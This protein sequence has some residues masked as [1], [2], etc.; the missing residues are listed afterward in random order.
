[1]AVQ[2]QQ[3]QPSLFEE[4]ARKAMPD[5]LRYILHFITPDEETALLNTIDQQPWLTDL[6]R[7]VQHYGWKYDY[8]ARRVDESMRLGALPD[9]L[10]DYCQRLYDEGHFPK[11]PNQVIINEYQPGQG[12]APHID[13]VPCFEETITS[14]SLDSLCVMDFTNPATNEKVSKLLE[15]RSLLIFSGDARYHWK[16]GIAARK[17]DKYDGQIIQRSRRISLTFR[18]VIINS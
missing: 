14:L 16:H 9:W 7:R 15:P 3:I 13:C 1:M 6:K 5:G 18:N 11:I 4:D 2:M 8:T 12:I 17:T 10:M